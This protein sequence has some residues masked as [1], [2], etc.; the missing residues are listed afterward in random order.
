MA[1]GGGGGGGA[2]AVSMHR[3]F[4]FADRQDVAMMAVGTAAA[5]ANGLA[6]PFLT[7]IM[8]DLVDA[9]GAADRA[10]VVHVVSMVAVRF[11]YVAIASGVA[12]FLQVSC[13]MVTG[14]RQAARMRGLYLETILRQDI[15]FFDAETSTGEIIERMS[16]DTVLIQEAIGEKVGKFLQLIS[17]FLGGFIIAFARGWLLS[18]VMLSSIPPVVISAGAMSL[19]VSRLSN[20]SQTAYA[21]AGKMVEQTIGSIRTVVSFTGEKRAIDRYNEFLKTSYR[22]TVHQ[23][24]AVGLGIGS[25]LL[26]IFCS[27]ALAVWYGARLIIEK[28]YTGGYIINVLMAIMTGAMALGNSS[29]CLSAFAS[30]RIAAYKMFATIYRTPEIDVHDKS[31]I[32]LEKFMGDVELRDV[33][34]SYPIRPEQSIFSGFSITIRTGTT[35]ALVGESGCGKSTVISLVER[36]YDPQSGEVLLDGMNLKQLNLSWIRQ[37]IGL[38]SQEPILFTTTIR[39]NIEYGKKGATEEEIRSATML[40]NAAKFIDMLPN[41]LDTRVGE[42]GTQLSGGQK[43]RIAIARAILKDPRILLLDEATSALDAES[44]HVVQ[45]ALNNIMVNRTTIIVAHRLSTVK[46]ADTISVLH[47]GQL[48][49]QGSHAEM[50][51]N[52]NGAY[53]QLV[54]LQEVNAKKSGPCAD[55]SNRMQTANYTSDHS[56]RKPSFERSMSIHSPQDG[57]RRNSHTFSSS[58][59]EKIGDDDVKLGKNVLRRLLHLHKPET[60]IL[61]LG[62]TA[63]AANGAILPVFGL[64]LSSAIKTFYEPPHKLRMDSVFWA[65]MYVT[66]GVLSALI[67]PVQYSMFYMAGGKLIERIRALS[68]TQVVYQ[69]IGWFDDPLN[70]SGAIGSRLSTDAASIRSIAGDVLALIVQNI[71]TVIVGIVIAMV[72]NWK[73]ACIVVC[74]VP[75]VFAQSYAQTRFMR[76]F[77][78]DAK[79]IYEQ[80]SIIASDAIGNIRTVASFCVEERIVENYRKKCEGPVKQGVRQGA[81]SGAGYGFSFALLFCFY[82]VS[83]YVGALFIHN[84]TSDVGQVF[85]VFFALTMMTVGVSQSSSMARDLSK[86][87]DAAVSIFGLIDRKSKIDASSE[88]GMTLG[89]VQG[90]IELQHVSFKYPARND[91]QIFRDL[92]LRIPSGKT[93]ALVGESGSGKSTVLSLIER[94]YDPD[95]GTIL[96]DGK[97]LKSLKLSWLRQQ[98]GL[99]GQEPVLFNDTIRAN[100]SYGKKEQVSEEEIIAVAEAANA[101]GFISALSSGYDTSVGERGVQLSGGQKQRIAIARAI[102]KDPKVLLLDEATSALDAES[103]HT[104]QEALDRVMVGRTTAIVAHRL[105]TITGADKI[106]VIKNGIVAEEGR[107]EQLL[108]VFPSGAYASLVAL[109]SS[110]SS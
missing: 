13:W 107:H 50:I 76:G 12:A 24:I 32:V 30:G 31:G 70:S 57:S 85:K 29:S 98:V 91:V 53:S 96:L 74:F 90:N 99:V 89:T 101:H 20:R 27:Y 47:R 92:C 54:R 55:N 103:E 48:V 78:A 22:S 19:V 73:L 33:H 52:S 87:E 46:N 110:S 40:A 59:H 108:R 65:E 72:A 39:Q 100:I 11:V 68:F 41:G 79:K 77:S 7:F 1:G 61:V 44:E 62:C 10:G 102:L 67:M 18:L 25:L 36:F 6:M 66:L 17:T 8:G 14:E 94:F 81:I 80:A 63:A 88:E 2:K 35:M 38:V 37:K 16:S 93:V 28:G 71:S 60:K 86:V 56:S 75:C 82:A 42:H 15:S 49:E 23:G 4:A 83:F 97:N 109:Q 45:E 34:F 58:E 51:K 105:S 104:V 3:L 9:F 69:E 43:Q 26:I 106:A 64:M 21:E 95:S 5:V 84:G